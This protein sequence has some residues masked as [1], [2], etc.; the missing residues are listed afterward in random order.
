MWSKLSDLDGSPR[1][2]VQG[3]ELSH[4]QNLSDRTLFSLLGFAVAHG[5]QKK[6]GQVSA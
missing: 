3:Q 5:T 4:N 2:T 1:S 6:V